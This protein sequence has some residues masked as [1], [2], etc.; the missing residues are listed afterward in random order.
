MTTT[1]LI[2]LGSVRKES[3][4]KRFVDLIF[5]GLNFTLIDLLDLKIFNY[6]YEHHYPADD[7]Y[8]MVVQE[9]LKHQL[10]IFATPVYWY[11]MSALMKTLFDRFSDLVTYKK[12]TGRNLKGKSTALIAVG[13]EKKLP[14]GFEI[15]FNCTS[16]YLDMNFLGTI[17]YCTEDDKPVDHSIKNFRSLLNV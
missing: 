12:T 15:P 7:Q 10:V 1:P 5:N 2:I 17:Y 13:A 14:E 9:I 8:D 11:S 3:D 16:S 6:D 4:T